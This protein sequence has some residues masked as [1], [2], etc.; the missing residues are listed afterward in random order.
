V[1][2]TDF[3]VLKEKAKDIVKKLRSEGKWDS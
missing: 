1:A 2:K 3:M